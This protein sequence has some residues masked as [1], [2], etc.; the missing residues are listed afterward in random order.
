MKHLGDITKLNVAGLRKGIKH[1]ENGDEET[2]RSGTTRG[3]ERETTEMENPMNEF[4]PT[5]KHRECGLS[6]WPCRC[7]AVANAPAMHYEPIDGSDP[8]LTRGDLVR[9]GTDA[10]LAK[11]LVSVASCDKCNLAKLGYYCDQG[12]CYAAFLRYVS[13]KPEKK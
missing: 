12:G 4:C 11:L 3:Q 10:E 7:C 6:A 5:C 8:E 13:D 2:T 9:L 1:E